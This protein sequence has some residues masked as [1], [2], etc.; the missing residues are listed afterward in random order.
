MKFYDKIIKVL[1]DIAAIGVI[2]FLALLPF[3]AGILLWMFILR[4]IGAM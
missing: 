4:T 3:A 2:G 1:V